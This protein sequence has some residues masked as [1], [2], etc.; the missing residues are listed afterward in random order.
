MSTGSDPLLW[1][2]H[3]VIASVVRD[4]G[5]LH[6]IDLEPKNFTVPDHRVLWESIRALDAEGEPVD[7]VTVAERADAAGCIGVLAYLVGVLDNAIDLGLDNYRSYARLIWSA[8]QTGELWQ[9]VRRAYAGR[10]EAEIVRI[11]EGIMSRQIPGSKTS[12]QADLVS[13]WQEHVD[14]YDRLRNAPAYAWGLVDLDRHLGRLAPGRLHVVLARPGLGKTA[15]ALNVALHNAAAGTPV[16]FISL[17]QG[18]EE[19]AARALC[20]LSGCA[21]R[22]VTGEDDRSGI[23]E[24]RIDEAKARLPSIPLT[25]NDGSPM[26][27][28]Q[29]RSTGRRLVERYGAKILFLDYL[30]T[31][32]TDSS[33]ARHEEIADAIQSMKI[34]ARQ[35]D[36]PVIVLA[37]AKRDAEGKR[38][39]MSDLKDSSVIEAEADLILALHRDTSPESEQRNVCEIIVLK[40]RHG[41]SSFGAR[42]SWQGWC[43][44][45][46][47]LTRAAP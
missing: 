9:Q 32:R 42:V 36:V 45:F 14:K 47:D 34:M 38:P 5:K 7:V 39:T 23:D 15:F 8:G 3:A 21:L 37:Q 16:G 26:D 31:I 28:G 1:A 33:N 20:I 40:N 44:R 29:V 11:A 19:L 46:A 4:P 18:K 10:E 27:I 41:E 2:E 35:L 24:R 13:S 6:E 30:Q 12:V 17:E 43:F 22:Q 25:F